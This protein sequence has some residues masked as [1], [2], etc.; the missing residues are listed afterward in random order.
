M[1]RGP[2]LLT[3]RLELCP[4]E[5]GDVEELFAIFRNA[6]VRRHLLDDQLVSRDWV[7]KEVLASGS[8]FAR[9]G[10]GLW[11]IRRQGEGGIVGFCGYRYFHD[12]PELQLVCGL[13]PT[14]WGRGLATE[15]CREVIRYGVEDL[16]FERIAADVD[17]AN[18]NSIRLMERL[19]MRFEG[20]GR[21]SGLDTV[22][23]ALSA[24]DL[25]R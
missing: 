8:H 7:A 14:Y 9:G 15:A 17:A 4:F 24:E 13:L 22:S 5:P 19:G 18:E 20:R 6:E 12:P 25:G 21:R 2:R 11:S 3:R 1:N 23:H 16:G 10:F